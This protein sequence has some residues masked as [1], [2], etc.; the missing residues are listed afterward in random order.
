MVCFRMMGGLF[1]LII[2]PL[3]TYVFM[4]GYFVKV[5]IPA[6]V[7]SKIQFPLH[8]CFNGFVAVIFIIGSPGTGI[9]QAL[10]SNFLCK[11]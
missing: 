7:K 6:L 1:R 2:I 8:D 3:A 5:F 11:A 4:Q 10:I 9:I